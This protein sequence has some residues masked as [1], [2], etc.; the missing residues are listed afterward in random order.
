MQ[1]TRRLGATV[2]IGLL[3]VG[4]ALPAWGDGDADPAVDRGS[5]SAFESFEVQAQ[6]QAAAGYLFAVGDEEDRLAGARVGVAKPADVYALAAA[7]QRGLAAGYFYAAV[8]GSSAGGGAGVAP[9]PPPGET[10]ALYPSEPRESTWE[11]PV[12]AGAKG[13][14]VDGRSAAKATD[15][16]TGDAALELQG[17]TVPGQLVVEGGRIGS[18]GAPVVAGIEGES[19]SV[20][21]GL[22][23]G[24]NLR[25]ET[26]TSR[27]YG[28]V[29]AVGG[30]P[31][32]TASTVVEGA[33]VNGTPV[34]ITHAGLELADQRPA[35]APK[36]QMMDQV[37]QALAADNIEDV[38]LDEAAAV[39]Q[40]SGVRA[41]AGV[42]RVIYRNRSFGASNPQGFSG[43]GFE[44]GGA[45]VSVTAHRPASAPTAA[46]T[47]AAQNPPPTAG[48]EAAATAV[49]DSGSP[50]TSHAVEAAFPAAAFATTTETAAVT[51][52]TDA[53]A[54]PPWDVAVAPS[55]SDG[56]IA[57]AP[58]A[59]IARLVSAG[60]TGPA[61]ADQ[62]TA[63]W[64]GVAFLL[65]GSIPLWVVLVF[66][67][68]RPTTLPAPS[69][70]G[71]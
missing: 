60:S 40:T 17:L 51:G 29:P 6:S 58:G 22:T 67:L 39:P 46:P 30:D 2:A 57:G 37:R 59:P 43:G 20:L 50:P 36:A 47:E 61:G 41:T 49:S 16:P 15:A 53:W 70:K 14:V 55:A 45:T 52:P 54:P 69:R 65:F 28:L 42:L 24:T 4:P 26:L 1:R 3:A 10:R 63:R 38:R 19:V 71:F 9:E 11:G 21:S 5:A 7:F 56:A 32:G 12:T 44:L 33:T 64:T 18:R 48:S 68:A 23:I 8:L 35:E 62:S 66:R 27:A 25:I 31:T 13:P 34:R